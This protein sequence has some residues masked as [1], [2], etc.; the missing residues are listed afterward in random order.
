MIKV[1]AE[2]LSWQA[3]QATILL[4]LLQLLI[5]LGEHTLFRGDLTPTSAC[6]HMVT[7]PCISSIQRGQQKHC[8][9]VTSPF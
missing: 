3:L 7:F 5:A 2:L 9:K 4:R 8:T 1:L 6:I